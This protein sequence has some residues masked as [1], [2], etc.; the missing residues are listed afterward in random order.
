MCQSCVFGLICWLPDPV[1]HL[2]GP[3]QKGLLASNQRATQPGMIFGL[4]MDCPQVVHG[5]PLVG[6]TTSESRGGSLEHLGG[7]ADRQ[8]LGNGEN[9][10]CDC[11]SFL[12]CF[13]GNI[14]K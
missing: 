2:K 7:A 6:E 1:P 5:S 4:S 8:T 3:L 14:F 13:H 9:K 12:G 11:L 10:L